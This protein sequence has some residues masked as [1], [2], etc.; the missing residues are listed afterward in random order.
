[1]ISEKFEYSWNKLFKS[2]EYD[3]YNILDEYFDYT[4]YMA[5]PLTCDIELYLE[6]D[7]PSTRL[8]LYYF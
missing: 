4:I 6:N 2:V 1:M 5:D 3:I 8:G 7:G